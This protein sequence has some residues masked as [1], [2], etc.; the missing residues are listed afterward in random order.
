MPCES[1]RA[2][3]VDYLNDELPTGRRAEIEK[4]LGGCPDCTRELDG[5]RAAQQVFKRIRV[6]QVSSDFNAKVQE[7]IS[8]KIAELRAKGSVRFRTARERVE[9]A[10][11]GLSAEEIKRRGRKAF[12]LYVIAFLVILPVLGLGGLG[13]FYYF[14]EQARLRRASEEARR[15]LLAITERQNARARG[16]KAAVGDDGRIG[17]MS[18]LDDGELRLV[19]HRGRGT[20]ERC[21]S[22]YTAEQWQ[23]HLARLEKYKALSTYGAERAE[24]DAARTVRVAGGELQVPAEIRGDFLGGPVRVEILPMAARTEVWLQ[25]DLTDYLAGPA[26]AERRRA[27]GKGLSAVVGDDGRVEGAAFLG[28]AG[29]HVVTHRGRRPGERCVFVYD[30]DQ[31]KIYLAEIEKRKGMGGYEAHLA[32]AK[33]AREVRA[34]GGTLLLPPAV[35]QNFLG[36]PDRVVILRLLGRAE[37]WVPEDLEEYLSVRVRLRKREP[38]RPARRIR[39]TPE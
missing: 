38:E 30:A 19:L 29:L 24:A 35:H 36:G 23:L 16:L 3:L 25:D 1:V 39:I 26:L 9:A 7:R 31:W 28:D 13:G 2:E 5:Y 6:K 37:I 17:G 33:S 10:R 22:L 27:R 11:E 20:S 8:K 32:A 4:H 12:K 14:K 34:R 21:L 15:A 18:F